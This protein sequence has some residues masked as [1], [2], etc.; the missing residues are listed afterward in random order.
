[1]KLHPTVIEKLVRIYSTY[2][3]YREE[4]KLKEELRRVDLS[5]YTQQTGDEDT[6]L[7]LTEDILKHQAQVK[8]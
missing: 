3:G 7:V 6:F 4:T 2:G 5:S 1:L 8:E